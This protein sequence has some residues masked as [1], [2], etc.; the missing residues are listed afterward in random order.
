MT[1]DMRRE[2]TYGKLLSIL[3]ARI[4]ERHIVRGNGT[5][6]IYSL[7]GAGGILEHGKVSKVTEVGAATKRPTAFDVRCSE[8]VLEKMKGFCTNELSKLIATKEFKDG[9]QAEVLGKKVDAAN[10]WVPLMGDTCASFGGHDELWLLSTLHTVRLL[11]VY[12]GSTWR[13]EPSLST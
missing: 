13:R 4:G 5:C 1:A 7:L 6:F 2:L 9:A 12:L 8:C 3:C 10:V 11:T